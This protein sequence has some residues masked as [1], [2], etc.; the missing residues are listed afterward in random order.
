MGRGGARR[1]DRG[2]ITT[3]RSTVMSATPP[4][5]TPSGPEPRW[6]RSADEIPPAADRR[7]RVSRRLVAL[8]GAAAIVAI[9]VVVVLLLV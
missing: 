1:D 9:V 7:R 5:P 6:D 4:D 2:T 8:V 3:A